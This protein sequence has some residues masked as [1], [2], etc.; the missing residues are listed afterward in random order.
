[1]IANVYNPRILSLEILEER[2]FEGISKLTIT[3]KR[4]SLKEFNIILKRIHVRTFTWINRARTNYDAPVREI[5][6]LM[7]R[8]KPKEGKIE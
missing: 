1:M 8:T 4:D 2:S 6:R 3:P 7:T 5:T